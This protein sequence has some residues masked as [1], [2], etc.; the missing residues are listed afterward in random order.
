MLTGA[1]HQSSFAAPSWVL[2]VCPNTVLGFLTLNALVFVSYLGAKGVLVFLGAGLWMLLRRPEKAVSELRVY[3]WIYLLPIW[4]MLSLLW[5]DHPYLS[6]RHGAQLGVTFLIAATLASRLS[7][8]VF[9][10]LLFCAL[11]LAGVA[12]LLFGSQRF[13]GVWLGIFRSKNYYAF[14]MVSLVLCAFALLAD[15][16][17]ATAWRGAGFLGLAMGLPQ[18]RM[19]ESL[20]AAIAT[21][22]VIAA[23]LAILFTHALPFARRGRL[24]ALFCAFALAGILAGLH[25]QEQIL[26]LIIERTGKDPSLTGRTELWSLALGEISENPLLGTGYRAFWVEGSPLAEQIW[27]DYHIMSKSGFNFHN[28]FLSNGV[29]VGLIGLLLSLTLLAPALFL[30]SRWLL[31]SRSG[32]AI[33]CFM[34]VTFVLVLSM[35]EVP[36]FFEFDALTV[37]VLVALMQSLRAAREGAGERG[38]LP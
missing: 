6:L 3:R 37:M 29:E 33:F 32:S 10:R 7:P 13:D 31:R 25:F 18:I 22:F 16:A 1:P 19:A 15:R 28:L 27:A 11:A 4:C 35:V 8:R 21:V 26:N 23:A 5:S 34:A 38:P 12:S 14:T 9:L 30:S 24:L 20:G 17:E 2:T 36:V